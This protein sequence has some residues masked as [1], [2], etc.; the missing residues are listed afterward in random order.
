MLYFRTRNFGPVLGHDLGSEGLW[1]SGVFPQGKLT[2]WKGFQ[3]IRQN[4]HPKA[5]EIVSRWRKC[6]QHAYV[7]GTCEEK[8][9]LALFSHAG[10]KTVKT[11]A[12]SIDNTPTGTVTRQS[13]KMTVVQL[14]C[15]ILHNSHVKVWMYF[16]NFKS[17]AFFSS[18]FLFFIGLNVTVTQHEI[19]TFSNVTLIIHLI[20][21]L[22]GK[23]FIGWLIQHVI[24]V[25][26]RF[27]AECVL[28]LPCGSQKGQL[29]FC[30]F[31]DTAYVHMSWGC[32]R[33]INSIER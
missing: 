27:I 17:S 6:D 20:S 33:N 8:L 30:W 7:M 29:V 31:A 9:S 10:L 18:F 5:P 21:P 32:F 11:N 22:L 2:L 28:Q 14:K 3:L 23:W 13:I 15:Y 26:C 12:E 16:I 25:L 24:G 4:P 1:V 19:K